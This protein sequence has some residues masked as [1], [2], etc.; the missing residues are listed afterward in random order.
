MTYYFI[1]YDL[2]GN[3]G[4]AYNEYMQ[5]LPQDTD[6]GV[7]TDRDIMFLTSDYGKQIEDIIKM[8]PDTGIFTCYCNRVG[9]PWQRYNGVISE[10]QDWKYHID[11]A[12]KLQKEKYLEVKEIPRSISGFLMVI[13]KK[14][15]QRVGGFLEQGILTIDNNFSRKVL[16]IG[17]KI[18]LM[19]GI[20]VFHYYRLLEG[21]RK[22]KQHLK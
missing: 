17:K 3:V 12:L 4:K 7:L 14:T 18:L 22:S 16:A 21:G 10:N 5:L 1:P 2:N 13:Q 9:N 11:L 8:Y 20:Y 19:E 15:W 6:Y